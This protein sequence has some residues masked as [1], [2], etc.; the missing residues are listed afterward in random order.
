MD[1]FWQPAMQLIDFKHTVKIQ[2]K[3]SDIDFQLFSTQSTLK[4]F[5]YRK[6]RTP[7]KKHSVTLQGNSP[8]WLLFGI[9]E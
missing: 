3:E 8:P 4:H 2:K 6:D 5:F 9:S 1:Y 7:V